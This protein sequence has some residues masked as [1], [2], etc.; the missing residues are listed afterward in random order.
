L[1]GWP[2]AGRW[3]QAF[4]WL[5]RWRA[6]DAS[7]F[8]PISRGQA[9]ATATYFVTFRGRQNLVT[10]IDVEFAREFPQTGISRKAVLVIS[11]TK[12]RLLSAARS[13]ATERL[14]GNTSSTLATLGEEQFIGQACVDNAPDVNGCIRFVKTELRLAFHIS[15]SCPDN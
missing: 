15:I 12:S 13:H 9:E 7:V 2:E 8:E 4:T 14:V 11:T 3:H 1:E 10:D 6:R 5:E